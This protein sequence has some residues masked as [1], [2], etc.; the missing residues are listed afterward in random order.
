MVDERIKKFARTLRCQQTNAE[1]KLWRHLRSRE[2]QGIKFRR[3][4][5]LGSY[6]ADFCSLQVMLII[7]L[8]G[9]QHA[10]NQEKDA[11][12]TA[13]LK[14]AGFQELR[15]WDNEVLNNTEAVLEKIRQHLK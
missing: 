15:F 8:D 9:N 5:P 14:S 2:F 12:R 4:Q 3:Q 13:Y 11:K 6:I 1:K 7:E 10:L